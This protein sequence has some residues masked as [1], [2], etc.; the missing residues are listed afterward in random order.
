MKDKLKELKI[1]DRELRRVIGALYNTQ[2]KDNKTHLIIL[3]NFFKQNDIIKECLQPFR[4]MD[5]DLNDFVYQGSYSNEVVFKYPID[6]KS[7]NALILKYIDYLLSDE[8]NKTSLMST[9]TYYNGNKTYDDAIQNALRDLVNPL[10]LYMNDYIKE[11]IE[12]LEDENKDNS[13][14][15]I[16]TGMYVE[17]QVSGNQIKDNEVKG[18]IIQG[19]KNEKIVKQKFYQ[20][21]GFWG[22]VLSGVIATLISTGII[23]GITELI[24]LIV[25]G[26]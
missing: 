14:K 26:E 6:N 1:T 17:N 15:T 21:E 13:G 4:E 10:Y 12:D 8:M 3:D 16:H 5:V 19:D 22:G 9:F 11:K 7:R 20:K 18:D 25:G 23:W 24:K 2:K